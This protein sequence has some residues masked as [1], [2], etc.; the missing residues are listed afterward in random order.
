MGKCNTQNNLGVLIKKVNP[1]SVGNDTR[2][3]LVPHTHYDAIW[4]FNKEDYFYINI[5]LILKQAIDLIKKTDYKFL[6]EQTFLLERVEADYPQLFAEVRKYAKENSIEV[7]GGQY[8]LSDV[9]LPNGEVLIREILEGKRYVKEKLDQDVI[10][11]WGADEFGFNAQWPQILKGCGYKYFAF[12]R[13]V[14]KPKPSEFLWSGLD[15]SSVLC[16]WMPLGYRAGLDVT[17]L[18]ESYH[19]LKEYAATDLILMPSGSGVTLPQPETADAV[20]DWNKKSAN[21]RSKMIIATASQFFDSLEK[22]ATKEGYNF[23]VRKGEMYSGRLSEVF[24][25]CL[26]SRMWIKQ[27]AKE[28][29]NTL[30]A[31][32]RWNAISC[33]EDCID[34]SDLL[35]NYWKKIL[36]IAMHDALP[37]TGIDEVY[38]EIKEIFDSMQQGM[39]KSL[40]TSLSELSRKIIIEKTDDSSDYFLVIFN[41]LPWEV[42]NWTEADLEFDEGVI[43]GIANLRT[44][45]NDNYIGAS[46]GKAHGN[47]YNNYSSSD[48]YD[49]KNNR[50]EPIEVDTIDCT[51]Y[52]DNSLKKI[53]IGFIASVPAFGFR[54]FEIIPGNGDSNP[55]QST[56]SSHETH[57][58]NNEF[59]IQ[60]NPENAT[61]MVSKNGRSYVQNGNELLLEEELG[62]LYYHRENLGLLKSESGAGVKY[63]SFK[64]E[65]FVATK[66][67]LRTHIILDSKY[68]A[69]RWPYRLTSK[70]KPL[71]YRHNFL[72]IQKEIIIYNDLPRIDFI[73]HIHDRHPH[74]RIRVK[75]DISPSISNQKYWSGTQFG[76]IERK[77]DQFY[78]K[79][80]SIDNSNLGGDSN[81]VKWSEKP[82]GIFP[83]LEWIDYSDKDQRGGV[84]LLHRGIPSHEIRDNSIY[85]TLLRSVVVLSSDGIMGPCIPTPDAAETRPYT[86]NYSILPHEDSWNEAA[87]YRHGIEVNMSLIAIQINNNKNNKNISDAANESEKEENNQNGRRKYLPSTY[88]FL[89]I[90]PKNIVLST[91]KLSEDKNAIIVRFYET[92]GKKTLA[93]LRF[94][95]KIKS[96]CLT[97]LLENDLKQV[98]NVNGNDNTHY[99]EI[100]VDP[101]KI[102]T[103]KV[104]F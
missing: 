102:V 78:H 45:V 14:D 17:K 29:E 73:T 47:N 89:Q 18:E 62:D 4:V 100:E 13:G 104:K 51:F 72:D 75:F 60:V 59:E 32:E 67:K 41:S 2:I 11:G 97:D 50:G 86:F 20:K 71:L 88:S 77:V 28:F 42:K 5:E 98:I 21:K 94:A 16:H 91:L 37:G 9:M 3:F 79:E 99:L 38:N 40:I 10:V 58:K 39:R 36:F 66:G 24:P 55:V 61:I 33:L 27:A 68:Y 35:R 30:L 8:L 25:D 83:S 57:F 82:T 53:K 93:K 80:D 26:S 90:D 65:N 43:R 95:K 103:L 84:S 46:N 1:D 7:A 6:I 56:P 92:E 54:S 64:Q 87:T 49:K 52:H 101:F 23:E 19:K 74:S 76:A 63:G 44:I 31:L 22:R 12:R 69:L 34:S 85:L 15:G 81:K 96:I 48:N 70:L